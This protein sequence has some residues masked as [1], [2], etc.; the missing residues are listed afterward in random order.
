M[1]FPRLY[2]YVLRSFNRHSTDRGFVQSN[3]FQ[4]VRRAT[5][6]TTRLQSPK[7]SLLSRRNFGKNPLHYVLVRQALRRDTG[8]SARRHVSS[9]QQRARTAGPCPDT[10]LA[11]AHNEPL[12]ERPR[13]PAAAALRGSPRRVRPERHSV[14]QLVHASPLSSLRASRS[15]PKHVPRRAPLTT[16][17]PDATPLS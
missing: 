13:P 3:S 8:Q 16:A 1:L 14:A 4:S 9:D 11:P 6:L 15:V 10:A 17:R 12:S 7:H 2:R 5:V